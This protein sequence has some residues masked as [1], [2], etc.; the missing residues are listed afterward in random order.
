ML[1]LTEAGLNC[2]PTTTLC[3]DEVGYATS[4]ADCDDSEASI[5]AAALETCGDS[6]DN[7]CD[8][9]ID[10]GDYCCNRF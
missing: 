9:V 2:G 5:N 3:S 10:N 6:T 7:N 4:N 1:M 8:D